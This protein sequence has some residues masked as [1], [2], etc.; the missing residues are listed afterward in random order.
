M[1]AKFVLEP[2][3]I[4]LFPVGDVENSAAQADKHRMQ[5][6][7]I[8]PAGRKPQ[9]FQDRMGGYFPLDAE[10]R[11]LLAQQVEQDEVNAKV[12]LIELL[13]R[14]KDFNALNAALLGVRFLDFWVF[15]QG[16]PALFL[17]FTLVF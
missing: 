13:P 15:L 17:S 5:P 16:V 7:M 8:F 12:G 6:F 11:F 9:G 10:R 14:E 2:A 4:T 1:V 3:E